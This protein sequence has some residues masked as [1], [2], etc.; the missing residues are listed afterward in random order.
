MVRDKNAANIGNFQKM[1][2]HELHVPALSGSDS[3]RSH[4]HGRL[5]VVQAAASMLSI[6][7]IADR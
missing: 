1:A 2:L 7:Y 3:S 6:F 5:D 4:W